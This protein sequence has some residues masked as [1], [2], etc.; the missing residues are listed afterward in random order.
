M[1]SLEVLK[2]KFNVE[3]HLRLLFELNEIQTNAGTHFFS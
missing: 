2:L 3:I 1:I